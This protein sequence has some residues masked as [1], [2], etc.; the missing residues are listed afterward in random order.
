MCLSY[1]PACIIQEIVAG[2]SPF[3]GGNALQLV[4]IINGERPEKVDSVPSELYKLLKSCWSP[5]PAKRPLMGEVSKVLA[6]MKVDF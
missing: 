4:S 6:E 1:L 2:K 5:K 3:I